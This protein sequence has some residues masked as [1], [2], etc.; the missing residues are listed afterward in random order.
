MCLAVP[1]KLIELGDDAQSGVADLDGARTR[2]NLS[3]IDEPQ[4]GDFLIV[5]AGF[6][7]ERLDE[8][9]ANARL[10]MFDELGEQWR[11]DE[12]ARQ[13]TAPDEPGGSN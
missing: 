11:K 7:I 3:L 9:E 4:L 5:H 12:A 1:M 6:A 13:E 2:V 8:G 10:E